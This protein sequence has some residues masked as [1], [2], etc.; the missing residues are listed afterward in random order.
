MYISLKGKKILEEKLE[1]IDKE[2]IET[3]RLMG[4]STKID[5][6]LR[7]NPEYNELQ[8][9]VSYKLP[10]EKERIRNILN[11]SLVIE[12]EEFYKEFEG[13]R[14]IIGS[15]V[16][17]SIDSI[18][19]VFYIVGEGEEDPFN[20]IISYNCDFA[21]NLIGKRINESYKYKNSFIKVISIELI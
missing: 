1:N 14:V 2:I 6:D 13:S 21:L 17:L 18:E 11:N 10:Y 20:N 19:E 4:E 9:K 12:E 5:N 15:K 3:Y 8:N 16:T 7:E